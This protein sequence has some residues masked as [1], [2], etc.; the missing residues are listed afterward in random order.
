MRRAQ[1][2]GLNRFRCINDMRRGVRGRRSID[3]D[4]VDAI[5]TIECVGQ[6]HQV[7][8]DIGSAAL[9]GFEIVRGRA[10]EKCARPQRTQVKIELA[11]VI[12]EQRT[13]PLP[14]Q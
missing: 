12:D 9:T 3:I 8:F 2:I 14:L 11:V 13:P 1:I 6:M 4:T 10:H 5:E 7:V